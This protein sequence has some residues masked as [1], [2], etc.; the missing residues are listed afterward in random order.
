MQKKNGGSVASAAYPMVLLLSAYSEGY[1]LLFHCKFHPMKSRY[2]GMYLILV[3]DPAYVAFLRGTL[4]S[5]P[6]PSPAM[7]FRG[8][9]FC[10]TMALVA[11]GLYGRHCT[12]APGPSAD[13]SSIGPR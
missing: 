5:F 12:V 6:V 2:V 13:T 9:Y 7:F 1:Y 10:L 8:D 4:I 3:L 11:A